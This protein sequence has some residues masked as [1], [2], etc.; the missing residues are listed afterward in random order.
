LFADLEAQAEELA[1][2]EFE[3]EVAERTRIEVGKLR[4]VDRLRAANGHPIQVSC[5]GA[6]SV[7]GRL[8]Q[9]GSGW[10]LLTEEPGHEVL[11]ALD[12]VVSLVGL[13]TLSSAPRSESKVTSRLDLR[14]ALRGIVRDRAPVQLV[15]VD[16]TAFDGTLDR[17]GSDFVEMAEHPRGEPRRAS[18]VQRVRTVPLGAIAAVRA[19]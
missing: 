6:G 15:L 3:G 12:A 16:G 9:V 14:Y 1:A 13:G 8:D 2:R 11:V 7:R 10:L 5:I 17:V 19:W 4:L 18:T